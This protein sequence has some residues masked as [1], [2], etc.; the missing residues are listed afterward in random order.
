MVDNL[1][2]DI[3]ALIEN[4]TDRTDIDYLQDFI[5]SA[6]KY[7]RDEAEPEE[8]KPLKEGLDEIRR[9]IRMFK[10]YK[11]RPK[12]SIFGS[13]RTK[14]DHVLY[15]LTKNFAY[16]A[17][18]LG[19]M[20]ITG[21][22]LG[23]MQAGNMGAGADNSFG[24]G[25][26]LSFECIN[27][28]F[29]NK[30]NH[31]TMFNNFYS[32]KMTFYRESQAIIVMPGGYGTMD[33]IFQGLAS[34]QTGK[35]K[36]RPFILLDEEN[37]SFWN[38][39]DDW[40]KANVLKNEYIDLGDL[41]LYSIHYSVDDVFSEIQNFYKYFFS[42]FLFDNHLIFQLKIK[43]SEEQLNE[44]NFFSR[45][46]KLD[47]FVFL[48]ERYYNKSNLYVYQTK[49]NCVDMVNIKRLIIALNKL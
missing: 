25:L 42:Y 48:R 1:K 32:R 28:I 44:L 14:K 13:A 20:I 43:L 41:C 2:K 31:M 30:P 17:K 34:M 6:V 37:G 27:E 7:Y 33:E 49:V 22:G 29:I 19:Y 5:W 18:K 46:Y 45:K 10:P 24:L 9:A 36:I 8:I 15:D 23:I 4:Y 38:S 47:D 12:I 16:M 3:R 21:G 35:L 26:D 39:F 40:M 11:Y